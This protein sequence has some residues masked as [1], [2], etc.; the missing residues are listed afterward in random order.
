MRSEPPLGASRGK[1]S[2]SALQ[3][4]ITTSA[5]SILDAAVLEQAVTSA[6]MFWDES[7]ETKAS[8]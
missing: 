8:L 1:A 2:H 3:A 4:M 6:E 7:A 5:F